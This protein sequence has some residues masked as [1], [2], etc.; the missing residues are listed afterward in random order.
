MGQQ[1]RSFN[2]SPERRILLQTLLRQQGIALP[3]PPEITRRETEFPPLSF[4]QQR[5]WFLE[6]FQPGTPAYNIPAAVPLSGSLDPGVLRRSV[7]EIVRRHQGLRTTFA[8]RE[9][10]PVQVIAP[11]LEIPLPVIDLESVLASERQEQVARVAAEEARRPFDLARGPLLR[12]VL[13]RLGPAEHVLLLTMHHIASDGWSM[14]VFFR[15]LTAL[16]EAFA[17]GRASPLPELP[18]QYADFAVW[19]RRWLQGEVLEQHLSYWQEQLRG[20]PEVLE[21]P[22][23]RP[24]P[25]VQ[26]FGGAIHSFNLGRPLTEGL[27]AFSQRQRVTLFMTLLAGFKALLFRYTGQADL[28]VGTPIANRTRAELEGLIGFFVNTLVLRTDLSGDPT[29]L[30]LL[31]RVRE[32][33]LGAYAHQDLPFEK[34]VEELQPERNLSHNPLFQVMFVF[35]Q[36]SLGGSPAPASAPSL[37]PEPQAPPVL[38]GTAKFDLTLSMAETSHGLAGALEYN[39]DLFDED[40]M[41][42]M[43]GHLITLLEGAAADPSRP[44]SRLPLLT[45]QEHRQLL[46]WNDTKAPFPEDRCIHELFEAQVERTPEATAVVFEDQALTYAE[47]DRRANQVAHYLRALGVGPEARVGLF[48]ERSLQLV[49]ALLGVLKAGG[50]YVPLDPAYPRE[51]LAFMLAD[52][53][54]KVLLTQ[55]EMAS[56]LPES[57]QRVVVLDETQDRTAIARCSED[58][59]PPLTGPDNLAYVIYTSGSTGRPKGIGMGHRAITNLLEWQV[60]QT[61][62]KAGAKTL[63]FMSLSFDVSFEEITATL[64]SGGTLVMI[65]DGLRRDFARLVDLIEA[66]GVARIFVPPVALQSIAEVLLDA[67]Q[68]LK[69]KH[70]ISGGEQLRMTP[71]IERLFRQ[72]PQCELHNEY[73][74]TE[75]HFTT[76]CKVTQG[77]EWPVLPPIGRPIANTQVYL[78]DRYLEQ[79]PIGIPG[80]LHA[81]GI[82]LARGYVNRPGQTAERFIPSPFGRPG[83]RLYKTGD[84]ARYLPDG[85]IEYLGR[86]DHQVKI[87]GFRVELGEIETALTQHPA[88]REAVVVLRQQ[89]PGDK[90][91]VAYLV[92]EPGQSPRMT[93]LRRYLQER[94]PDYMVPSSFMLLEALPLSPNGK[95]DRAAL[96]S[97]DRSRPEL[98]EAFVAPRGPVEEVLAGIWAELLG[99]DQVGVHDNFFEL[100][101][102][103]LLATQLLSRIRDAFQVELPLRL[104]FECPTVAEIADAI[105]N[106][107]T[108]Q[109]SEQK[110]LTQILEELE[111]LP[112]ETAKT[113]LATEISG[114]NRGKGKHQAT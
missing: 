61:P 100:G 14:G 28:V 108:D 15:E 23:D 38:T 70:V 40:T 109:V 46:E 3:G 66:L 89:I 39:T 112:E 67:H 86:I 65:E 104:L 57:P 42:R 48:L 6:Q 25:P 103:S 21:L 102:H 78:L 97:P 41:A 72:K 18:V 32:V 111:A 88:V 84:L 43:A 45:E 17:A 105:L 51:R 80:E 87:R 71:A 107:Q 62:L 82:C 79:V 13:L 77:E 12:T 73:G 24:R 114:S 5:L 26:T 56:R 68:L 64:A 30:E 75:T 29:F 58:N 91:L 22:A 33:T 106:E 9:G 83:E 59:P 60:R 47:L 34:L 49:V 110:Q 44:I 36:A 81:G 92:A 11:V 53:Q 76:A 69:L 99:V 2:L 20:A 93:K 96:P 7:N 1:K 10:E 63:Q 55:E 85:N 95:V 90:W 94:L 74:P 101:G 50:A 113:M 16:Y 54:A 31:G 8:V 27:E 52:A 37:D 98:E 19:Q 4:A 35:Q